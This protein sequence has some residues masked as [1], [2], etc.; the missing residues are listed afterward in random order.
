MAIPD[1]GFQ[2]LPGFLIYPVIVGINISSEH[3]FCPVD[4]KE[5]K[6]FPSDL[7]KGFVSVIY[8]IGKGGNPVC[9]SRIRSDSLKG[10][11]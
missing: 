3:G 6:R 8:I 5:R 9:K 7:L 11:N 10:G 4:G 2:K 1:P